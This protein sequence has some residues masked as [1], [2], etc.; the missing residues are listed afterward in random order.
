MTKLLIR[1]FV[2]DYE[3]TEDIKVRERYGKFSGAVGIMSNFFLCAAKI[4]V[5]VLSSSIAIIADGI[6][7]LSDASSSIIT[8]VGFKLAAM[9]EDKEHPYGHERIEYLTGIIISVM[10]V[11]VGGLLFKS[12]V[13]KIIDPQAVEYS[14]VTI[15]ILGA[16]I[17]I[18]IWQSS[19][20]KYVSGEIDSV[21]L[22]ASAAD[23]RNDVISTGAVL[24]GVVIAKLTGLVLDGYIGCAVAL[25]VIWS[26]IDLIRET[27]SPLLGEAP[28][29][30]LVRNIQKIAEK[31][32][33]VLGIHDLV[34]HNYGPGKVFASM[35]VEV[36]SET[37][38]MKSHDMIDNIERET[39]DT[40]HVHFVIHMDPVIK[41][42]PELEE[43]RHIVTAEMESMDG[44]LSMH[45]LRE[46]KGP[47]HT[48]YIFD[49]VLS[50]GCKMSEE[51]IHGKM[52]DAIRAA[53][54][55]SFVV[56]TFDRAYTE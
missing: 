28:D 20:Y 54:S 40:L 22:K 45:D 46:V 11:M 1:L 23:S 49:V 36:D 47:T 55:N 6:N 41:D 43:V 52:E 7:N 37:D 44:V 31:Y 8:L 3:N 50:P 16:A 13:E 12:S 17:V 24:L 33:G 34:V 18:K 56:M 51:E 25:F 29:H 32:D 14:A 30:E 4:L 2:K 9:P 53:R 5:G 42:D 48:N 38:I 39:G 27:S 19:F 10:I 21:T 26:G 15:V 35:H